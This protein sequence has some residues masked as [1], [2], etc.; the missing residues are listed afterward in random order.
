MPHARVLCADSARADL[1]CIRSETF[2]FF[3]E[4]ET[5]SMHYSALEVG[6]VFRKALCKFR[7]GVDDGFS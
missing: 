2:E 4:T 7:V 6:L 1:G 5:F 3:K